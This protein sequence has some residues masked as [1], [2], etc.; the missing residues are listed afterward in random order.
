[1]VIRLLV[2]NW[3]RNEIRKNHYQ[4]PNINSFLSSSLSMWCKP[5]KSIIDVRLL[6]CIPATFRHCDLSL[7]YLWTD[8]IVILW[9][10]IQSHQPSNEICIKNYC[11][12]VCPSPIKWWQPIFHS[13]C[14]KN[15]LR[16][17]K[18][19]LVS[20]IVLASL[21]INY[22]HNQLDIHAIVIFKNFD[23][24]GMQLYTRRCE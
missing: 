1:M 6:T 11:L 7:H 19:L 17:M 23:F 5:F 9:T 12:Y 16:C 20:N 4:V 2:R 18:V 15:Y 10:A 8:H 13:L 22:R 14:I 24:N 3:M 21:H